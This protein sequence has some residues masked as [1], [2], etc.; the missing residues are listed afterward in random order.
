MA[1]TNLDFHFSGQQFSQ[2]IRRGLGAMLVSLALAGCATQQAG[3]SDLADPGPEAAPVEARLEPSPSDPFAAIDGVF[4][5][6]AL[7]GRGRAETDGIDRAL[8]W[9]R[10]VSGFE[11]AECPV[12][13]SAQRWAIWY[14]S[15]PDYMRRVF[16][17]ARPWM[18]YIVNE[19]ERRG[20]P[21][22]F[23]LLPVVESAFDP[24]A[25]S[26]GRAS[27]PW[28][29]LAGTARD[30]GLE[31]NDWYDGRRDYLAA[32]GAALDYLADLGKMFDGD[33][34][35]ATAAYNAGQGR[36]RRAIR[37]NAAR[38]HATTWDQLRLP[39]ETRGY[40]PK[41]KGLACLFREPARYGFV[42]PTIYDRPEIERI[43]LNGPVD[44]AELA[45]ATGL[46][47]SE[48]ITL[49]AG[50][51]RPRTPPQGPHH[52]AVSRAVAE[53]VSAAVA[54]LKPLPAL[55]LR[56]VVV[57]RGDTLSA[58]ALRHKTT[59]ETLVEL[60][61]LKGTMLVAG[62]TLKL[63]GQAGDSMPAGDDPAY[64]ETRRQF[65]SLQQQLL[66]NDRFIHR[67][68]SGESLW[69]IARR[70]G[71]TVG[72][73]QR[74]NGLGPRTLIR[75]GQR[76]VIETDRKPEAPPV[77]EGRY[78]VRQGDSL[79]RIARA[80]RVELA[81]LMRWNGLNAGSILR[82]GQELVIRRDG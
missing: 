6:L 69:V 52:L 13:S 30:Y 55:P 7:A 63:P 19:V 9:P 11:F 3:V 57:R 35:L 46:E 41:L 80:Q 65:A 39:R 1:I 21:A 56:E 23:A 58:L 50:L 10:V 4:A 14:A 53:R 61:G 43:A 64:L 51:N 5:E 74:M 25:Y 76:L 8:I 22:E 32:T 60:N 67:V 47:P 28:Q 31:I 75:P 44:L 38:G 72:E 15:K 71:V 20:L 17:R 27:G 62:Q 54:A 37:R 12:D 49:N 48:F 68:R 36:V 45:L 77:V 79:W 70:Y 40:V 18:H 16:N 82:P 59:I 66:P 73:L 24:F 29:F 78:I 34:A 26:H 33:W 42:L 81:A 2:A